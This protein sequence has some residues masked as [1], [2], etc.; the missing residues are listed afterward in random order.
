MMNG[1]DSPMMAPLM[2]T[3][4]RFLCAMLWLAAMLMLLWGNLWA[5]NG[6][7]TPARAP[8]V[9][10]SHE[11]M[12]KRLHEI[13]KATPNENPWLGDKAARQIRAQLSKSLDPG[14]IDAVVQRRS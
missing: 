14:E 8:D 3:P 6:T 4:R 1:S 13:A 10:E 11:K 9:P 12:L 7:G 5:N 2:T